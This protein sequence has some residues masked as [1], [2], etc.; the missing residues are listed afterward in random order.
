MKR[1]G[2]Q[3]HLQKGLRNFSIPDNIH[4]TISPVHDAVADE[5]VRDA[6][7]A[8]DME[9]EIDSKQIFA[10][11]ESGNFGEIIRWINT[12]KIDP[13]IIPMLLESIPE[14]VAVELIKDVVI[15]SNEDITHARF[16]T[17][18]IHKQYG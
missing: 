15:G 1:M 2:W 17:H 11:I 9:R 5:F 6:R 4:L 3:V 12:G 14:D 18:N 16:Y 10:M 7:T 13:S 8:M